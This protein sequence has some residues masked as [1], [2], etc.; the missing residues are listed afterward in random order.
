MQCSESCRLI[1]CRLSP[2]KAPPGGDSST[3]PTP[4]GWIRLDLRIE[5]HEFLLR[6]VQKERSYSVLFTRKTRFAAPS[7]GCWSLWQAERALR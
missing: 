6:L 1:P 4:M 3:L 7:F 2:P 5:S